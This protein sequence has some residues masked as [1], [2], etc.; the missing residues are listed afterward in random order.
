ML[1]EKQLQLSFTALP[2]EVYFL[3]PTCFKIATAG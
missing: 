1:Q 3:K 2:L